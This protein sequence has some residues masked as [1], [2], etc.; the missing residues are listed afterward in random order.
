MYNICCRYRFKLDLSENRLDSHIFGIYVKR[1]FFSVSAQSG[2][3]GI[4]SSRQCSCFYVVFVINYILSST[5]SKN[6]SLN[7]SIYMK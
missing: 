6:S 7:M 5:K 4:Q 1:S 2:D 3:Q